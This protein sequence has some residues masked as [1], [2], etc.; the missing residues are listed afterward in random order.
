M[1]APAAVLIL[2]CTAVIFL[3]PPAAVVGLV[4]WARS[5]RRWGVPRFATGIGYVL[6]ALVVGVI[7]A[8]YVDAGRV[9]GGAAALESS[10][11]DRVVARG[12]SEATDIEALAL[13]PAFVAGGWLWS[14]TWRDQRRH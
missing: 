9:I 11:K 5:L 3:G 10:Q 2:I 14:W 8:G 7:V 13:L 12:L 4:I 1:S 6:I